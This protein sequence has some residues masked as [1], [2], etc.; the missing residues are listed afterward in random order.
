MALTQFSTFPEFQTTPLKC[1]S[2]LVSHIL[3]HGPTLSF[4]PL[5]KPNG[6]S[7]QSRYYELC[8]HCHY[9]CSGGKSELFLRG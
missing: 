2:E 6:L 5:L 7:C 4:C 3:I 9:A 8:C 1:E